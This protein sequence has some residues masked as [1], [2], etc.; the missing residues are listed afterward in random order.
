MITKNAECDLVKIFKIKELGFMQHE[1]E[2]SFLRRA[3]KKCRVNTAIISLDDSL[4]STIDHAFLPIFSN[5]PEKITPIRSFV[6]VAYSHAVYK[7]TDSF[8]QSY[9]FFPLY[10]KD[11]GEILLIGPYLSGILS[12]DDILEIGKEMGFSAREQ[13]LLDRYFLNLPVISEKSHLFAVIDAFCELAWG[14]ASYPT[15]DVKSEQTAPAFMVKAAHDGTGE[16]DE[17]LANMKLMEERYAW[18]NELMRAV[19]LG[20][21]GKAD[22]LLSMFS[23][24][25]FEKRTA[26]NLRNMKNYCIIMNTLL[27]KAAEQGGV[28]PIYLDSLSSSFALKIEQIYTEEGISAIMPEMLRAYFRL[29]RRHSLASYSQTVQRVIVMIDGDLSADLSLAALA[30]AQNISKGYL[31]TI[32]KQETGKTISEF[33]RERRIKHAKRLLATTQLQIQT[34]AS[35][36]GIM[37]L[38]YFSKIFKK[39]TGKTPKEYRETVR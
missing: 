30:K 26:D 28:H 31:A 35:Q 5:D 12:S 19:A 37:D 8:S 34:I 29:V 9:L 2:L 18:E 38:Q 11:N 16:L 27:R 39:I 10:E 17:T 3:L 15:I 32:F 14:G 1:K 21:S 33:V 13:N 7:I 20:Q 24:S 36:C 4:A 22:Q 6:D 25:S 23:E